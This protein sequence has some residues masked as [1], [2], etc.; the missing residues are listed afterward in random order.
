MPKF[1]GKYRIE[2]HRLKG[3]DYSSD[4]MYFITIIT[5]N[6]R[7][8]FGEINSGKMILNEF[9]KITKDEWLKSFKIRK[10][11]FLDNY[12][13][14]PNHL[15]A[16]VAIDKNRVIDDAVDRLIFRRDGRPTV[17]TTNSPSNP[18]RK[19]VQRIIAESHFNYTWN[20]PS[21]LSKPKSLSS[22]IGGFKSAVINEIDNYIDNK[23]MKVHKF[24]THN[25]LWQV[26]F[27]D[28]VIRDY[29]SYLRITSYIRNNP[30]NWN[31][32]R[33]NPEN[34]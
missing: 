28:H 26:N 32:D 14:M 5:A 6:R 9:G 16:I 8:I 7:C 20:E 15:H 3:W 17:S 10:E 27:H 33:I 11:L 23:K 22:F 25:P 2:S 30:K 13:V 29:N 31:E 18:N 34:F 21:F 1:Q 4:G 24:N 19:N 12:E